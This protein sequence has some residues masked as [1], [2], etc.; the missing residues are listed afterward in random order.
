VNDRLTR[1][2]ERY[3]RREAL[4]GFA[5]SPPLPEA[6]AG[7]PP[8]R[9]LDLACGAGRH[10]LYLAER[11]WQVVAVDGAAEGVAIMQAEATRRGVRERIDARVADLMSAP[12]G[13]TIAPRG[14]DLILDFYFLDRSL[15]DAI[16]DGVA[17]GGCFVAAIHCA[18]PGEPPGPRRLAR[19]ELRDTVAAW[20]FALLLDAEGPTDAAGPAAA[21]DTARIVARRPR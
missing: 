20:G 21:P 19:G 7:L 6:V 2:N 8:G 15:F 12:R 16:R 18:A 1:W 17:P 9:A 10:A 4:P 5:P 11:G 3:R 14:Y 13:F